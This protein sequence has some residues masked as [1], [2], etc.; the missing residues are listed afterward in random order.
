ML[1]GSGGAGPGRSK[2]MMAI[3]DDRIVRFLIAGPGL[4]GRQHARILT[5]RPDC[6]IVAIVAPDHE[7]N[8]DFAREIGVPFF[9][10]LE[11]ALDRAAPDGAVIASPNAFHF[12]QTALCVSRGVPTL[13]EKPMTESTASAAELAEL[14]AASRTPVLVGHH[15]TYSPLLSVARGFLASERFGRLVS[16]QGSAQFYKPQDYFAAGPWRAE[17]GGGPVLINLIHEI[18]LI[19][20]LCGEFVSVSVIAGNAQRG[21]KVE[22]TVAV[23]FA[24]DNGALGTFLLSDAAAS[25]KSW[26]MTSGENPVYP[27]HV[28]DDCYHFAGDRGSLDFPTMR[29]RSYGERRSWWTPFEEEQ[30]ALARFDPLEAQ[31]AH[32]VAVIR[33]TEAPRVSPRDGYANMRVLEAIKRSA[34][35]GAAVRLSA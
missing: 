9:V 19:R 17:E 16:V 23:A 31:M 35:T 27:H 3:P 7:H 15:R 24:L 12:E 21:F 5:N 29:A 28:A 11:D 14:C 2:G 22:D 10:S 26:E 33:G 25:Q 30:L 1:I 18:G 4:I 20:Y 6:E 32:F 13:V 34:A 8:T